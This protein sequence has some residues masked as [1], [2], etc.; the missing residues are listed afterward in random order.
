LKNIGQGQPIL[1]IEH[2]E[3]LERLY[4]Q[5]HTALPIYYLLY[6]TGQLML[7]NRGDPSG[8]EDFIT[9]MSSLTAGDHTLLLEIGIMAK[10]LLEDWG[11]AMCVGSVPWAALVGGTGYYASL[12]FLRAYRREKAARRARH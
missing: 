6:V 5:R 7:G 1:I 10:V 9:L 2:E 12:K 3:E 11:L 8:Y 4:L